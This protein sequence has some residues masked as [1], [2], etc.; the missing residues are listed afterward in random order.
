[1]D[2]LAAHNTVSQRALESER[3]RSGLPEILLRPAQLYETLKSRAE[4]MKDRLG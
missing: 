4:E 3:A 2:A 1:M